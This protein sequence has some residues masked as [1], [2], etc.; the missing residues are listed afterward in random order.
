MGEADNGGV[1]RLRERSKVMINSLPPVEGAQTTGAVRDV[2]RPVEADVKPQEPTTSPAS[3]PAE[4]LRE[5]DRAARVL[6]QL[7]SQ[8]IDLEF[9][10]DDTTRRVKV[11][12]LDGDGNVLRR[13]PA[14]EL[15]SV[16]QGGGCGLFVDERG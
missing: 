2:K 14:T 11:K 9:E 1:T 8:Q 12:I 13:L 4:V 7:Q 15:H 5:V 10:V 16:L 6:S 3:P